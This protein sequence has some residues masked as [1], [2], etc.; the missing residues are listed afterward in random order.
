MLP[1][2]PPPP[3]GGNRIKLL[4]KKIKW[5]R[6]EGKRKER[7]GKEGEGNKMKNGMVGKEIKLVATLYSPLL[8]IHQRNWYFSK[9]TF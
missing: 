9:K 6:R 1:S 7:E 8:T 4:G 2:P 5:G 3:W